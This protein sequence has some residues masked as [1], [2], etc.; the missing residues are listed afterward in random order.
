MKFTDG[1]GKEIT[2]NDY[3]SMINSGNPPEYI[4]YDGNEVQDLIKGSVKRFKAILK[5][6]R[7]IVS[8]LRSLYI[9][10]CLL[11]QEIFT[12][13]SVSSAYIASYKTRSEDE[14]VSKLG[15]H[16]A[17]NKGLFKGVDP[18]IRMYFDYPRY[19]RDI[20]DSGKVVEVIYD[21]GDDFYYGYVYLKPLKRI[22]IE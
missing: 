19:A 17:E 8:K 14:A 16:I 15:V 13:E 10:L 2:Y 21:E 9:N 5:N 11:E 18:L 7:A 3:K 4:I 12:E 20:I 1:E 6:V 22:N